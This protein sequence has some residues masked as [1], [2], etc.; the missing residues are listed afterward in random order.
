MTEDEEKSGR[1]KCRPYFLWDYD[2]T[3]DD[4]RA[5]LRGENE[6]EKIQMMVRILESARWNDIW[7]YLTLEEVK[8]YWPQLQRRM[9]RELR[10]VWAWAMEMEVW[11]SE[12]AHEEFEERFST[13][14]Y[15]QV[16]IRAPNQAELK[17]DVIREVGP[18]FGEHQRLG[19]VIVD[20]SLNI[21]VNKV[22]AIYGRAAA[23]DYVDLYFLLRQGFDFDELVRLAKEKDPGLTEFYL[24]GMLHE[25]HQVET[26]PRMIEPVTIEE[27]R[28]Y[29]GPLAEKIMERV[30]PTE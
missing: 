20:S 7:K 28:A 30:K 4:V 25:I 2:L 22:T 1:M 10:D 21:A 17:V 18:Q 26:L 14:S 19:G 23:K 24:A 29:F 11:G 16:F 13:V 27:L 8:R 5:I 15:R 6:Y 9:R 12:S 3:E